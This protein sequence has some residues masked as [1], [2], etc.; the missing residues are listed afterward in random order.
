MIHPIHTF[1]CSIGKK[2]THIS[3]SD[4]SMNHLQQDSFV[5]EK[6]EA[7]SL[8]FLDISKN[9]LS[10][11]EKTF[12]SLT[13][14]E[15]L[16]TSDKVL[17]CIYFNQ[18]PDRQSK[19]DCQSPID[20]L[21]S[22]SDVL[23]SNFLRVFLWLLSL[24]SILGNGSVIFA[25]LFFEKTERS[26][27]AF[28]ISLSFSDLLMGMFLVVIGGA[29]LHYKGQFLWQRWQW[30]VQPLCTLAGTMAMVSSEVSAFMICFIMLD[31]LIVV[32]F[33]LH[34]ALHFS[35]KS[36][37]LVILLSW[38][39]GLILAWIP[40]LSM[41]KH[42]EFYGQNAICLPLPITRNDFPGHKYAF[43][44]FLILNFTI[45]VFIGI[46]QVMIYL[47]VKRP[48]DISSTSEN[49]DIAIAKRLFVVVMSDFCCWFPVGLMGLLANAGV[50]IP[51]EVNVWTAVFIL[52]LNSALNPFL[53][54]LSKYKQRGEVARQE[55]RYKQFLKRYKAQQQIR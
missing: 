46:G 17:C 31:R 1:I 30:K 41:F 38:A 32:K 26:F 29:D 3:L 35:M 40:L 18:F 13:N 23:N 54:T 36:A 53:Y 19:T 9:K 4:T 24:T 16:I 5:C 51:S 2:I 25:R 7:S 27:H 50:P 37:M 20:E 52:L 8:Q 49:K 55:K 43:S 34:R 42:W 11:E 39:V 22:C 14:L 6:N 15:A 45:F 47:V 28:V 21:S 12:T 33:P 10:I 44:V 48:S